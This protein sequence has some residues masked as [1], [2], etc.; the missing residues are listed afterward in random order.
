MLRCAAAAVTHRTLF[1]ALLLASACAAPVAPPKAQPVSRA[2]PVA[3]Q[4]TAPEPELGPV[5]E[6][7]S[8]V[9]VAR[10]APSD[11][12][13]VSLPLALASVLVAPW[14]LV[15]LE[16]LPI[17]ELLAPDVPTDIVVSV[18]SVEALLARG[19]DLVVSVGLSS[20]DGALG[21][22]R[23]READTRVERRARGVY[24]IGA[25]E[26]GAP[27]CW[28]MA[29]VGAAPARMVC[30]SSSAALEALAPY[31]ARGMPTRDL[32]RAPFSVLAFPAR[33]SAR[34][35]SS[36]KYLAPVLVRALG[37]GPAL[38]D[39][40]LSDVVG[41]ALD[42]LGDVETLRMTYGPEGEGTLLRVEADVR[43]HA[44]W[45]SRTL[46]SYAARGDGARELF[47]REP[48]DSEFAWFSAGPDSARTEEARG[49]V[50]QWMKKAF[51]PGVQSETLGLVARTFLP[52]APYVYAQGD[53]YG[54]DATHRPG[55]RA[56]WEKTLSTYGWHVMG[57]DEPIEDFLVK[58]EAG[59]KAYDS[60]DLH[61]LAYRELP[62]LCEGLGKITKRPATAK[63]LPKGSVRYDLGLPGKFFDDCVRRYG[64]GPGAPKEALIVVAVPDGPRTWIGLGLESSGLETRLAGLVAQSPS[65][66]LAASADLETLRADGVKIG[67]FTTLGG[68][69][70]LL[71]FITMQEQW[72]WSRSRL[73]ALPNHGTTRMPF[74]VAVKGSNATLAVRF[75]RSA[76]Q[77]IA[78]REQHFR[79]GVY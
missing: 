31:A 21:A 5:S 68:I 6:P 77:D 52:S 13:L 32:G 26:A 48:A 54:K 60:G 63:G 9:L 17:S 24:G 12:E 27:S 67:G 40:A 23:A 53:G 14:R 73:T 55:G 11:P 64:K 49:A 4:P 69:G 29:S 58:L 18:P 43:G 56:L 8:V 16:G 7:S 61:D 74:S 59:M 71:R 33:V 3:R 75:P 36:A 19:P 15:G 10:V 47:F 46:A 38:L 57:Y 78:A 34:L 39:A 51:G 35:E 20:L 72:D 30:G 76:L 22:L 25:N 42:G 37:N 79:S 65:A 28:L 62:F 44:S 70:G 66:G 45:L 50:V 2:A 1:S 41:D